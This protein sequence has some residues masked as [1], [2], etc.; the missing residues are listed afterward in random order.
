MDGRAVAGSRPV[1]PTVVVTH[2][3][4]YQ[5]PVSAGAWAT[6][7]HTVAPELTAHERQV[8]G[9]L[10]VHGDGPADRTLER[11]VTRTGL[12]ASD[13]SAALRN[14]EAMDPPLV[15]SDVDATLGE[16]FW[17]A[18]ETVGDVLDP[19]PVD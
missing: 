11:V 14:L 19:P 18:L 5:S 10:M 12:P 13:V 9:A 2:E 3:T 8:L 4:G 16:R 6:L 1:A 7:T 15:H 17:I